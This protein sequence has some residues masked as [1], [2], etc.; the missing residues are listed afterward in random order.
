MLGVGQTWQ[1]VKGSRA[2]GA[3]YTNNTGKPIMISIIATGQDATV[4]IYIGSLLVARQSDI[5]DGQSN[6]STCSTIVPPGSTYRVISTNVQGI[7]IS[8][9]AELR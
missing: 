3:T 6:T 4:Q 2:S 7:S 5:Y 9:W 1:D 8:S